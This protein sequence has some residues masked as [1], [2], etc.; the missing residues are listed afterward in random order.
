MP[1]AIG[2]ATRKVNISFA[3]S[4]RTINVKGT[5]NIDHF[6]GRMGFAGIRSMSLKQAMLEEHGL[7]CIQRENS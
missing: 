5:F 4:T 1:F 2:T 7:K 6:L 3:N